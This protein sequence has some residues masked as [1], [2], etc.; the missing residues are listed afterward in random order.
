MATITQTEVEVYT[1]TSHSTGTIVG[2]KIT[3]SGGPASV[4]LNLSTL[5]VNLLPGMQYCVR[6]RCTNSEEYTT[7][8]TVDYAFKTLILAEIVS[9][10]GGHS[11][12]HPTL[13]FTY[14]THA[15]TVSD[16]GVYVSTNASG[17]NAQQYSA[18]DEQTAGQGW[19]IPLTEN[20]TY[21]VIPYVLDDLGREYRGD[22]SD[23]ETVSTGYAD[24]TVTIS[25]VTTTYNNVSGNVTVTTNATLSSVVLKIQATGGG[26]EYTKT[27][28]AQTGVQAWSVTN[29]DLDDTSA[30]IVINPSTEYRVT[31]MATDNGGQHGTA[32]AIATTA[33]QSG[34]TIAITSVSNIT[35]SSAVVNLTYGTT[36]N[37]TPGA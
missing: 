35:P 26:T 10:T 36:Q 3:Q 11:N 29:G 2:T 21:Y 15:L 28:T 18:G 1:G 16:C 31:I 27:L 32:T 22:W 25:N 17:T 34:A 20:T 24:P 9:V 13:M 8:W 14:D 33:A 5:G 4:N 19:D 7:D 30:T 23:A 37:Q 12:I 6:A